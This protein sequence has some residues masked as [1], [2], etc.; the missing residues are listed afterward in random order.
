MN[1]DA[2]L[3]DKTKSAPLVSYI[4]AGLWLATIVAVGFQTLRS[5]AGDDKRRTAGPVWRSA[6][7]LVGSVQS[8]LLGHLWHKDEFLDA[9]GGWAR[10]LGQRR[11]NGVIRLLNGHLS[12]PKRKLETL[13]SA[14]KMDDLSKFCE[15]IG[16]RVLFILFPHKIDLGG[17]V[18][19][20]GAPPSW[21]NTNADEFLDS[22]R[23]TDALDF[24]PHFASL[25]EDVT[26]SFFRTDHH[27]NFR[28]AFGAFPVIARKV[29]AMLGESDD[30]IA[31]L[32][33]ASWRMQMLPRPFLG[34]EARRTGPWF[35]GTD[36]VEYFVPSFRTDLFSTTISIRNIT[37][38]RSGSFETAAIWTSALKAPASHY[39][40]MG[41]A[42]YGSD[43]SIVRFE[44]RAAPV[45]K[46]IVIV[47]DSFAIPVYAF[48]STVFSEVVAVDLRHC[49]SFELKVYLTTAR[50]DA[51]LVAYNPGG[52][53]AHPYFDFGS[54]NDCF[55]GKHT[56]L[57]EQESVQVHP[58]DHNYNH[59]VFGAGQIEPGDLVALTIGSAENLA[60]D[61]T[62]ATASL[63]DAKTKKTISRDGVAL[64][65]ATPQT[66]FFSVP[67]LDGN[68]RIL[69]YAGEAGKTKGRGVVFKDVSLERVAR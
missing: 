69:L 48:L 1:V 13:V 23:E 66:I 6:T 41:Y 65:V 4:V 37:T 68:Y 5:V 19:P 64:G 55:S 32:D 8:D 50:P 58:T 30:G 56:I 52:L 47:K 57:Q 63:Y 34:S 59:Y 15:S 54:D 61:C 17:R 7:N 16:C 38:V 18:V 11:C 35:G 62:W 2:A 42:I 36:T 29:L 53:E 40:D 44:N 9:N 22:L 60:G 12:S 43:R 26:C 46:R 49:H 3:M 25:P 21:A 14:A 28:A 27:W 45:K 24:R 10:L 31:A 67:D 39:A 33:A 20:R 51:V